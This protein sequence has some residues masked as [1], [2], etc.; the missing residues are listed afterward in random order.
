MAAHYAHRPSYSKEVLRLQLSHVQKLT[1]EPRFA[2]VGA[3]TGKLTEMLIKL[4]LRGYAIEPNAAM[5]G[6]GQRS[7]LPDNAVEWLPGSAEATGLAE[8]TVHWLLMASAF[9]WTDPHRSLPEFR[10]VLKPGGYLTLLWN[11]RN[12]EGSA[13]QKRIDALVHAIAPGIQRKSSGAREFT[14][15]LERLLLESRCF[16]EVVFMEAS[17]SEVMSRERYLGVWRSVNDIQVQAGPKRFAEIMTAIEREIEGM[18][19]IEVPYRTRAWFA[20]R[21]D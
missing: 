1:P 13:L 7:I 17:H 8:Q 15:H 19:R 9:H 11:P 12:L 14:G 3:G 20:R 2:D 4:G 6:V 18:D 5:R 21:V 16:E 10:R